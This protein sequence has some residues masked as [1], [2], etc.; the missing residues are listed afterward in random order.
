MLLGAR[1]I[2]DI[3][4]EHSVE[5]HYLPKNWIIFL[6]GVANFWRGDSLQNRPP[7]SPGMK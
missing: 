2:R 5:D 6:G 3:W 1:G 7:G 4:G